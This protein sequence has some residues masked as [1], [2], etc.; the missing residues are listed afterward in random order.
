MQTFNFDQVIYKLIGNHYKLTDG[1]KDV[2][3]FG[4]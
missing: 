1:P 4:A 3:K 2:R